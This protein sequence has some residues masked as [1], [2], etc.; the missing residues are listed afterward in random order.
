[1]TRFLP[2]LALALAATASLIPPA[3]ASSSCEDARDAFRQELS[4]ADG[5]MTLDVAHALK[6]AVDAC[7][8][9]PTPMSAPASQ[10]PEAPPGK[11]LLPGLVASQ[12]GFTETMVA[13]QDDADFTIWRQMAFDSTP[14]YEK[15]WAEVTYTPPLDLTSFEG[16]GSTYGL[17]AQSDGTGVVYVLGVPITATRAFATSGCPLG[18]G[19]LCWGIASAEVV[20]SQLIAIRVEGRLNVC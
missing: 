15:G 11:M 20:L 13:R 14:T 10:P 5:V 16:R 3:G 18:G 9:E 7:P 6:A 17:H 8:L 1:M 2:T 12:C 4:A 19:P